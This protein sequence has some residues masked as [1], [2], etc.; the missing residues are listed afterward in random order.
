VTAAAWR[1]AD[2]DAL[3]QW[4][5]LH[6][7]ARRLADGEDSRMLA[8]AALGRALAFAGDLPE[9]AP[10]VGVHAPTKPR[11]ELLEPWIAA[12]EAVAGS[13][14]SGELLAGGVEL[15]LL[16]ID[17]G[18][19]RR[20]AAVIAGHYDIDSIQRAMEGIARQALL[21][22]LSAEI[23]ERL[24]DIVAEE[25]E[26]R[27]LLRALCRHQA[28]LAALRERARKHPS[29]AITSVY[30]WAAVD[31]E[32]AHRP[33]AARTLLMLDPHSGNDVRAL[34][35]EDGPSTAEEHAELL[36]TYREAEHPPP[37]LDVRSAL[38]ALMA[39]PLTEAD[40]DD[41]LGLELGR[42]P[43]HLELPG[44]CA[45]Y[46]ATPRPGKGR[47]L[48]AWAQLA[49]RALTGRNDE[50]PYER[51]R[52]LIR[53]AAAELIQPKTL[54]GY[55]EA[56]ERLRR[57]AGEERFDQALGEALSTAL[58]QAEDPIELIAITFSIW[59]KAPDGGQALHDRVLAPA[60]RPYKRRYDDVRAHFGAKR[61]AEWDAFVDRHGRR[62]FA[63]GRLF[64]RRR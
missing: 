27:S 61:Q 50:V 45:W 37:E 48:D 28:A 57:A 55:F 44:Y 34:W 41:P 14:E 24:A 62:R 7:T 29:L 42:L 13:P 19:D 32:P 53:V 17:P 2:R 23:A 12:V 16:G 38:E 43:Q 5:A 8:E 1:E 30:L 40:G 15:G 54:T 4:L 25:P 31:R 58:E 47:G 6:A 64:A 3:D 36:K 39:K 63:R 60:A 35:G 22:P 46:V 20:A 33:G 11:A 52:E 18:T 51:E 49:A 10:F 56:I 9:D 21:D 59:S 26:K